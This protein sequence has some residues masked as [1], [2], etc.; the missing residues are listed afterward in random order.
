M[1]DCI[2]LENL[3]REFGGLKRRVDPA[4][5]KP[6]QQAGQFEFIS[7]QLRDVQFYMH[8]RFDDIDKQFAGMKTLMQAQL[9]AL[10]QTV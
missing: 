10:N 5:T 3:T 8:A 6:A 1:E 4:E 2:L 9:G 7:G